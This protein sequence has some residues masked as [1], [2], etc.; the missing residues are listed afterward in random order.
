[1]HT[2]Q[3][4]GPGTNQYRQRPGRRPAQPT[5]QVHL[6]VPLDDSEILCALAASPNSPPPLLR[7][8]SRITT[9]NSSH[10]L[11]IRLALN[12][13]CPPTILRQLAADPEYQIRD[14]VVGNPHCPPS[15]LQQTHQRN[16]THD[17][18][19][20]KNPAC[21]PRLLTQLAISPDPNVQIAVAQH[22]RCPAHIL[23]WLASE[24]ATGTAYI[25]T[26][27]GNLEEQAAVGDIALAHPACPPAVLTRYSG[28][29]DSH[30]R[31]IVAANPSS[32]PGTLER[33]L[34]DTFPSVYEAAA[35]NPSLPRHVLAMWQ[36][37]RG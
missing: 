3:P 21:P 7:Q 25:Q 5:I 26:P 22:P 16:P 18:S 20:A 24:T 29:T 14:A 1:M 6:A 13:A 35:A 10:V 36:L 15:L 33:L 11:K 4:G 31:T 28:H 30:T 9:F 17:H 27:H 2:E 8:I 12:P 23:G 32:P 34:Q 19:I 37:A